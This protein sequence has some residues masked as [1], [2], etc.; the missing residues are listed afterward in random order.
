MSEVASERNSTL[1]FP[2]PIELLRLVDAARDL[3]A[4]HD[5]VGPARPAASVDGHDQRGDHG[6]RGDT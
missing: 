1:I 6:S 2:L 5:A 3:L 4:P